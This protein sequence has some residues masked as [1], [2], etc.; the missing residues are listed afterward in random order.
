MHFSGINAHKLVVKC[1]KVKL[2]SFMF[3]DNQAKGGVGW[4]TM[5]TTK[6]L[7]QKLGVRQ[8]GV[9]KHLTK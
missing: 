4:C 6:D 2:Y 9:Y 3:T 5:R 7:G 1:I 8:M